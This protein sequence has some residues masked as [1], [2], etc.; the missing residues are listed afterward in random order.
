MSCANLIKLTMRSAKRV[1]VRRFWRTFNVAEF[2]K[3]IE[4]S[5]L[6]Q[7]PSDVGELFELYDKTLRSVLDEHAPLKVSNLRAVS[8]SARWYN[9]EC[10]SEKNQDTILRESTDERRQPSRSPL[11]ANS[12]HVR[13][14]SFSPVSSRTGLTPSKRTDM[15]LERCG[16]R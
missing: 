1:R 2:I 9:A 11:G 15:T 14:W 4:R 10:R 6:V 13:D 12:S 7:Q 8:S 16:R 3:D 5:S